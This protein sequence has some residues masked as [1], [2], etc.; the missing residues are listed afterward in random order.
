MGRKFALDSLFMLFAEDVKGL[1]VHVF[2]TQ[3]VILSL[4]GSLA[5]TAVW[6]Q[7]REGP[8]TVAQSGLLGELIL[9][10][11]YATAKSR[12]L[13]SEKEISQ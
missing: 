3:L 2:K 6:A 4:L 7:Q 1:D 5:V 12:V 11:F 8:G 9:D 10:E 13:R